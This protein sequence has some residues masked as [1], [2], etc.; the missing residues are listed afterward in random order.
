MKSIYDLIPT[1]RQ[2]DLSKYPELADYTKELI[3]RN[4]GPGG[5]Y[6]VSRLAK[7]LLL[8]PGSL[9]IDLGCGH[10][11]SSLYLAEK[12]QAKVIAADLWQD[13]TENARRTDLI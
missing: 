8:Q 7:A 5:L 6:L 10:A 4:S 12:Y 11:E 1:L 13:P 2:V 9:V 3:W